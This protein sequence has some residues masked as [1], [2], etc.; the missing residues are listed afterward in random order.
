MADVEGIIKS[1]LEELCLKLEKGEASDKE[2]RSFIDDLTRAIRAE[3]EEHEL[4]DH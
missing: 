3:I 4:Y 1:S 2:Q